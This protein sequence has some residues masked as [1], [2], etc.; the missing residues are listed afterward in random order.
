M[1]LGCLAASTFH[2]RLVERDFGFEDFCNLRKQTEA[3]ET[4][5]E[6]HTSVI[7]RVTCIGSFLC[8]KEI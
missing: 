7:L 3:E 1:K 4:N 5:V 2:K 6:I 8:I